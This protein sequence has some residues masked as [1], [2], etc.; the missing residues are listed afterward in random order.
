MK[1]KI[2]KKITKKMVR[3]EG[4]KPPQDGPCSHVLERIPI[5]VEGTS[6]FVLDLA[7]KRLAALCSC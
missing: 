1:T 2:S 5:D 7:T 6:A 3:L 4:K